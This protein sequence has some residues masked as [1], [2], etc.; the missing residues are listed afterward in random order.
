MS[1]NVLIAEDEPHLLELFSRCMTKLGCNVSRFN[2]CQEGMLEIIKNPDYDLIITDLD[3]MPYSGI[4][5][6]KLAIVKCRNPYIVVCTGNM[7]EK[8]LAKA[9]AFSDKVILKT[10]FM[11]MYAQIVDL[12]NKRVNQVETN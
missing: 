9:S 2:S 4:D 11:A 3:Q 6:T 8:R 12:A 1:L 10:D 5:L 7:N